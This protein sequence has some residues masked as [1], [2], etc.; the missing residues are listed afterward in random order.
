MPKFTNQNTLCEHESYE[1][2][3]V[4]A[5]TGL[6]AGKGHTR[7]VYRVDVP[8]KEETVFGAAVLEGAGAD[9]LVID[10]CDTGAFKSVAHLPYELVVS[11]KKALSLD[12]KF[13][14]AQS[15]PDTSMGNFMK[16]SN[17]PSAITSA[18]KAAAKNT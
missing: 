10:R 3:C 5:E 7:F 13:R 11:G 17:C 4:A 15:F 12:A 9:A 6:R 18:L 1:A 2:A 16:I 8:G 14:I